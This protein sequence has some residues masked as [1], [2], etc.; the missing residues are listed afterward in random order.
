MRAL[1]SR[2]APRSGHCATESACPFRASTGNETAYSITS[3][4]RRRLNWRTENAGHPCPLSWLATKSPF[5][6]VFRQSVKQPASSIAL[7]CPLR[8]PSPRHRDYMPSGRRVR[9]SQ[10]DLATPLPYSSQLGFAE[11]LLGRF[12]TLCPASPAAGLPTSNKTGGLSAF[13]MSLSKLP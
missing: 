11:C 6:S 4:A 3:S 1:G 9:P 10:R 8:E 12:D 7:A 13:P 5:R 2:F